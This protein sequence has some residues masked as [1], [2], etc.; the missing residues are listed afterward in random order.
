MARSRGALRPTATAFTGKPSERSSRAR[1]RR[2]GRSGARRCPRR[3]TGP[4]RRRA[5]GTSAA[6]RRTR[7]RARRAGR[8]CR[9]VGGSPAAAAG[10]TGATSPPKAYHSTSTRSWSAGELRPVV[11]EERAGGGGARR[12]AGSTGKAID[13]DASTSTANRLRTRAV[14]SSSSGRLERAGT[15][16]ERREAARS[17]SSAARRAGPGLAAQPAPR[18]QRR[19]PS[20]ASPSSASAQRGQRREGGEPPR[21]VARVQARLLAPPPQDERE[22][23]RVVLVVGAERVHRDVHAEAEARSRAGPRPPACTGTPSRRAR[24]GPTRRRGRSASRRPRAARRATCAS[25]H[26]FTSTR[27]PCRSSR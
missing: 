6:A 12:P 2:R 27:P 8:S 3:R 14:W 19:R 11:G 22:V 13:R 17:A 7:P 10:S 18:E 26:G 25:S 9:R 23:D 1:L 24:C 21:V 16:A 20:A 4:G 5:C 15:T